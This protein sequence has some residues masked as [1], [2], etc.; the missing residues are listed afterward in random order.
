MAA[1]RLLYLGNT[2]NDASGVYSYGWCHCAWSKPSSFPVRH[3]CR[4]SLVLSVPRA[5]LMPMTPPRLR[6][7]V[8][9][10]YTLP[11]GIN[12]SYES[13]RWFSISNANLQVVRFPAIRCLR[14]MQQGHSI[15]VSQRAAAIRRDNKDT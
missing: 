10:Q 15:F 13:A 9:L 5:I 4:M 2:G 11:A 8:D 3:V 6:P 14:H 1:S 7:E 12:D